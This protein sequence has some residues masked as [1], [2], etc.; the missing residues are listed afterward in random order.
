[1]TV[2]LKYNHWYPKLL[3]TNAVSK[4]DC[5]LLSF[6]SDVFDKEVLKHELTHIYQIRRLGYS[7]WKRQYLKEYFKNLLSGKSPYNAYRFIS[8]EI[9]AFNEQSKPL[10]EE[11][12]QELGLEN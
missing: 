1:M 3:R 8:F 6:P 11:D 9:E 4:E 7:K 12:K 2:E 5:I 10:T